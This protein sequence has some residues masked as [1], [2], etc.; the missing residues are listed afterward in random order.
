MT[1]GGE[2]GRAP[3]AEGSQG[4]DHN[5]YGFTTWM[6]GGGVKPGFAYGPKDD[7]GCRSIE[8]RVHDHHT[9]ILHLMGI[10]HEKLTL[11]FRGRDYR[12]TDLHG[13]VL[14]DILV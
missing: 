6:D 7:F 14:L 8:N 11:R 9:T 5:H 12:L 13:H 2:F 10:D 4:R 3:T 1:W